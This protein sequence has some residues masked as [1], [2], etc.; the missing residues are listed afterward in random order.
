MKASPHESK[1]NILPDLSQAGCWLPLREKD[2]E[3]QKWKRLAL[4]SQK[5]LRDAQ[6]AERQSQRVAHKVA[7]DTT[8]LQDRLAQLEHELRAK[9]CN[10]VDALY[11]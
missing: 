6:Q 5:G 9:V 2:G 10:R 3:V 11:P 8:Q 7:A 1:T 4:Q